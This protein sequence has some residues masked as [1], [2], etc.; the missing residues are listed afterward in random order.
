MTDLGT[1]PGG[2]SS[3]ASGI[4]AAGNVVGGSGT[5]TGTHAFLFTNGAMADL[6]ALIAPNL[7]YTLIRASGISANGYI[8][9]YCKSSA[10]VYSAYLLTPNFNPVPEASSVTSLGL[11][12]ALGL[13]GF[14]VS[15]RRKIVKLSV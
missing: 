3:A 14:A 5:S 6:N 4:D 13:G 11:L 9:G 2:F 7:G 12:L 15:R 8:T 10:G 1:L